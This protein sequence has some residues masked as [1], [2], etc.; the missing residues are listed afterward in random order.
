MWLLINCIYEYPPN[1]QHER[2]SRQKLW[3][4]PI[5]SYQLLLN[6]FSFVFSLTDREWADATLNVQAEA[7]I[8]WI[9]CLCIILLRYLVW[10]VL[11]QLCRCRRTDRAMVARTS[12]QDSYRALFVAQSIPL[13]ACHSYAYR[14]SLSTWNQH[15]HTLTRTREFRTTIG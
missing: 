12:R 10:I 3:E 14:R 7:I 13:E 8:D 11:L 4:R 6:R 2:K 9:S 15:T 1:K 5:D